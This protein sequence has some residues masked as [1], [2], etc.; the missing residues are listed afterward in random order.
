MIS[1]S[2]RTV[3]VIACSRNRREHNRSL[4]HPRLGHG[5]LS[6]DAESLPQDQ[7]QVWSELTTFEHQ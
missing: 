6:G 7:W 3:G 4:G 5:T 2:V 1:F